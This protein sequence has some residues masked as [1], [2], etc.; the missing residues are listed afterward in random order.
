MK[1]I[2][3][4]IEWRPGEERVIEVTDWTYHA[5]SKG[6]GPRGYCPGCPPEAEE[7]DDVEC[8]WQDVQ[9]KL[10]DEEWDAYQESIEEAIFERIRDEREDDRGSRND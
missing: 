2:E 9:V 10:T 3:I 4:T 7:L 6:H 8:N 1:N 5:G